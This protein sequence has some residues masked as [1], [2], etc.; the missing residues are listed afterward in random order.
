MPVGGVT[1]LTKRSLRSRIIPAPAIKTNA[2]VTMLSIC[3][4]RC[5]A[6]LSQRPAIGAISTI[7]MRTAAQGGNALTRP[8][9][10][11]NANTTMIVRTIGQRGSKSSCRAVSV[12]AI[13]C[14]LPSKQHFQKHASQLLGRLHGQRERR[15]QTCYCKYRISTPGQRERTV[16][17]SLHRKHLQS[18]RATRC[19]VCP[20]ALGARVVATFIHFC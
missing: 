2:A 1:I 8:G 16:I 20:T 10:R 12:I 6:G 17:C 5:F 19:R 3:S 11:V 15:N 4:H 18:F 7:T 14:R 9:K 13:L